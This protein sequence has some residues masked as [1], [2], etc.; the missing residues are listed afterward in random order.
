MLRRSRFLNSSRRS[1]RPTEAAHGMVRLLF[2]SGRRGLLVF[3]LTALVVVLAVPMVAAPAKDLSTQ[4]AL[5]TTQSIPEVSM[6]TIGRGLETSVAVNPTN[7]SNIMV[8]G[9]Q[10]RLGDEW[11]VARVSS[12]SGRSWSI[13]NTSFTY[14]DSVVEDGWSF[15]D[16]VGTFDASGNAYV[17]TIDNGTMDW[18]FKSTDGGNNFLLTSPFLKMNDDL[19]DYNSGVI[20][21][22]CNEPPSPS[23]D[24][25]AVIADPYPNSAYRDSI[26]VL[27][28]TAARFSPTSCPFGLAFER[29]TDGGKTWRSG[30]WLGPSDSPPISPFPSDFA[31]S[32]NRGMAVA[33]DGTVF[34][35]GIAYCGALGEVTVLKSTDGGASFQK[36]CVNAPNFGIEQVEATAASANTF[37][38]LFLGENGTIGFHLYSV[39][40]HDGGNSWS[41]I[42]RVDDVTSPDYTHVALA[43]GPYMWDFSHSQRTGRLDVAWFDNRYSGGNYNLADLYYSYSFDG[44]SWVPNVW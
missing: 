20:V 4:V 5:Q 19:L 29:S 9:G 28:R 37:Y 21:H 18:L 14:V 23:R 17:G 10:S 30:I 24:Y 38:V 36:I 35:A 27:V 22:P 13:A 2:T 3:L 15:I 12:D 32:G 39:V 8:T 41:Q 42:S 25:P 40:S 44:L 33:P 7:P 11:E 26:Y 43:G 1:L 16:P 31:L 34:L 6:R